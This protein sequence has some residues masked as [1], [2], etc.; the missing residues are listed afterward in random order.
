[1]PYPLTSEKMRLM[2]TPL[3]ALTRLKNGPRPVIGCLPLYPPVELLHSMG[4][5]PIVLWGLSEVV[6]NVNDAD[7]HLQNYVC[8]VARRLTQFVISEWE[9]LLDGL[10]FYNAGDTLRNLPEILREGVIDT[11]GLLYPQFHLHVPMTPPAQTDASDYLQTQ[12]KV[13]IASLENHYGI[14]FS[15]ERFADSVA[16]YDRMRELCR[17]LEA[18]VAGGAMG[19]AEFRRALTTANFLVVNEQIVLLE[20]CLAGLREQ[21]PASAA[22][23]IIVSGILPPPDEICDI[24]DQAGLRVVG[25]DI[26]FMHR[27]Y[28][29]SPEDWRDVSDYYRQF[30]RDHFPCTTLLYTADR[31]V[32]AVM[33]L[34]LGQ[35]ARG[36]LF[37]GEKFCEYEYFEWPYLEKQLKDQGLAT[38]SFEIAMESGAGGETLRTRL[39]AF[40]EM[41][42]NGGEKRHGN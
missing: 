25:N 39:E 28:A 41:I 18:A 35:Q 34:A 8:S 15:E 5:T 27:A 23:P 26:A 9:E 10:F 31:R 37:V 7:R 42:S 13:L 20:S 19:F 21:P 33:E 1:V 40:R 24:M 14:P 3:Q 12:I 11:G 22:A 32:P 38:L 16:L 4:L 6:P 36:F 2:E 29:R 17:Q 30:Y